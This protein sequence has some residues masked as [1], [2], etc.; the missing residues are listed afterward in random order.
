MDRS[1]STSAFAKRPISSAGRSV[2]A[3]SGSP[4][5]IGA[6]LAR[7]VAAPLALVLLALGTPAHCETLNLSDADTV[8]S[9]APLS[10]RSEASAGLV[11]VAFECNGQPGLDMLR[12]GCSDLTATIYKSDDY[13]IVA[14]Y[15]GQVRPVSDL[16]SPQNNWASFVDLAGQLQYNFG[17]VGL[18]ALAS[19]QEDA[20]NFVIS[21]GSYE[22]IRVYNAG[23]TFGTLDSFDLSPVPI[24]NV[25]EP[26]TY[27]LLALA[28][29]VSFVSRW[30]RWI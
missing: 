25:P 27:Q 16:L 11:S 4:H 15:K 6:T 12:T 13:Q 30:R 24:G 14:S 18:M 5:H 2:S 17:Y 9:E 26:A 28:L 21:H 20:P 19:I 7:T 8:G 1:V 3:I 29:A 22:N 23:D 10:P